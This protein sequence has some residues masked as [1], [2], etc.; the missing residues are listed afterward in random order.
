MTKLD[1][2]KLLADAIILER[3]VAVLDRT[4][5]KPFEYSSIHWLDTKETLREVAQ[6]K[7]REAEGYAG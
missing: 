2:E 3:A 5:R 7:R 6:D 4:S 1:A